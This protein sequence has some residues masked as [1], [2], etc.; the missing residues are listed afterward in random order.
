[1][2]GNTWM[3]EWI[4]GDMDMMD[5]WIWGDMDMMDEWIWG[6]THGWMSGY[7]GKHM[8]G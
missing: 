8:D 3:D 2:G 1:M 4:W 7:G 5:E 6:E